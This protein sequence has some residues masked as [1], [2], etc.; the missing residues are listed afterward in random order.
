VQAGASKNGI[1]EKLLHLL[2]NLGAAAVYLLNLLPR[3]IA[4]YGLKSNF[5]DKINLCGL[6]RNSLIFLL[7]FNNT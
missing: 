1:E 7:L 5:S 6:W 4:L 3:R 2:L